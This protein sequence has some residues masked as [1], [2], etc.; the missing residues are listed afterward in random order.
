M[1]YALAFRAEAMIP[2]KFKVPSFEHE[3]FDKQAN[4]V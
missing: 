4:E 2:A 1:P 3:N